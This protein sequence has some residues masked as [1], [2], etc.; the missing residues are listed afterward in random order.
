MRQR[1]EK[2]LKQMELQAAT[3]A[4]TCRRRTKNPA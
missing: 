3:R 2:W 4:Q 1:N